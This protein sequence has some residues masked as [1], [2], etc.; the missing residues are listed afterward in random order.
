MKIKFLGTGAADWAPDRRDHGD[1]YRGNASALIND[2]ILI[3]PGPTVP[4]ALEKLGIAPENIKYIINTHKHKDHFNAETL[5]FLE[6]KG[7]E[8]IEFEDEITLY[9][10]N[11]KAAK[12]HHRIPTKHYLFDD[13]KGRI[14]YALDSA[15]L[16]YD[17][18]Q[19][20]IDTEHIDLI[21]MDCTV[22][23]QDGDYRIFEHNNINMVIEMKKTLSQYV[24]SF[25]ISHM[26]C[27][28][29]DDHDI[30][31]RDLEPYGIYVAYDGLEIEFK[32]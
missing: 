27:G 1:E 3:D 28:L 24:D 26:S 7:A 31:C 30:I 16:L 8:F 22:G 10:V 21:V 9:G 32:K 17:E 23:H 18:V 2:C 29:H 19:L 11:I 6:S 14:Y 12:G 5:A 20:I 13:G 15:W 4:M 25:Y